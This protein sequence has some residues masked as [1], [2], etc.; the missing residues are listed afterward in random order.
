MS[1]IFNKFIEKRQEQIKSRER[2]QRLLFIGVIVLC[3]LV[4]GF[5]LLR[6]DPSTRPVNPNTATIE[7]L[8]TLPEV[9]PDIAARIKAGRPY[10]KAEDLI[11]VKGIGPKTLEKIKPRLV[12]DQ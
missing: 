6:G 11:N 2:T 3:L 5:I 9:G 1:E 12:F 8:T 7:Q 4:V 10:T